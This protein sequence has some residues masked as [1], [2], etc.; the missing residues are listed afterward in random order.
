MIKLNNILN[1]IAHISKDDKIKQHIK[2]YSNIYQKMIKLNN[3]LNYIAHISKD[4][5]IKQHIKLYSS[6][7]KR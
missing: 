2:L 6:Y 1:S 4:D 5:K 7:I 3:I